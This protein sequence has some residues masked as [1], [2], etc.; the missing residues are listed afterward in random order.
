MLAKS[1]TQATVIEATNTAT[2][3]VV[4][5]KVATME[6]ELQTRITSYN[7][8]VAATWKLV[9]VSLMRT[10]IAMMIVRR[11]T[12]TNIVGIHTYQ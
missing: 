5:I 11:L 9:S 7:T 2:V 10:M 3:G 6:D 8:I 1:N 4:M 12:R